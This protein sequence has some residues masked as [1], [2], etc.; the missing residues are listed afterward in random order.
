MDITDNRWIAKTALVGA[1][2]G[3]SAYLIYQQQAW[4][5]ETTQQTFERAKRRLFNQP[6]RESISDGWSLIDEDEQD[7]IV[8]DETSSSEP[9]FAAMVDAEASERPR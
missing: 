3:F 5:T 4:P 9:G 1:V 7:I 6:R 8:R 2:V